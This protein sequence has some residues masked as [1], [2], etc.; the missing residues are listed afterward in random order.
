MIISVHMGAENLSTESTQSSLG[1]RERELKS[2]KVTELKSTRDLKGK[3]VQ[4]KTQLNRNLV[5]LCLVLASR[6]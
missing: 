5:S 3:G 2:T 6:S 1:L 4:K